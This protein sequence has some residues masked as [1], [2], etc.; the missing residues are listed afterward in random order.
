M[1][2][3]ISLMSSIL[4]YAME[5]KLVSQNLNDISV[6][7]LIKSINQEYL[8]LLK[9]GEITKQNHDNTLLFKN[10]SYILIENGK[11]IPIE[12][13]IIN[14]L[15][16]NWSLITQKEVF[17]L[18]NG[19]KTIGESLPILNANFLRTHQNPNYINSGVIVNPGDIVILVDGNAGDFFVSNCR[20]Y[21]GSTFKLIKFT[22]LMNYEFLI[23]ILRLNQGKYKNNQIIPHLN[24]VKFRND[25]VMVPPI[26]EQERIVAKIK[27]LEPLLDKYEELIKQ[28][29]MLDENLATKL[30]QS[31]IKSY[32]T[33]QLTNHNSNDISAFKLVK[34]IQEEYDKLLK[35]H[36]I[37]KQRNDKNIIFKNNS[38]FSVENKQ[39]VPISRE[40]INS[41]PCNWSLI[42]QKE[43]FWLDNGVKTIGESL[44]ILNA[45]FL[46]THQN[47]N[48]INSGVIVNPGDIVILVDGN[49]GDFF[50]S[51]CRGYMGSTFKLIKFTK[52]MNYEFLILILRL[53]QGKYKN[54]QII[55]HLNKV[56]FRND[57]VMVPPIEEQERI[58]AKIKKL[59]PLIH[60][61]EQVVK[62]YKLN[63]DIEFGQK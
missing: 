42:T 57:L 39:E 52:L 38:Y 13:K 62:K 4:Q 24:K 32:I 1:T 10:N 16:K 45:N 34:S 40:I 37:N 58:V 59:E 55:P 2:N 35:E 53:N 51:N 30:M 36:K 31:I 21:M 11:E 15:P 22:K 41:L 44:P 26:E 7:D 28:I 19:V 50:V 6:F 49:A 47:P 60:K 25:L 29:D 20:G 17:W 27:K 46:R 3:K 9:N 33:G 23:L 5:G 63:V 12:K 14:S 54:N 43:V 8:Y 48:Y 18:D 56:K 61:Y